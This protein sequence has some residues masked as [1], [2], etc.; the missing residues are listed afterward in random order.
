MQPLLELQLLSSGELGLSQ[1]QAPET[2]T[3]LSRLRDQPENEGC[4]METMRTSARGTK[5]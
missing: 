2:R 5:S 4:F 1:D 3:Y